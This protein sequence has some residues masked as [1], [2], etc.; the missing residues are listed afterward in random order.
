MKITPDSL[1][2]AAREINKIADE[3]QDSTKFPPLRTEELQNA[4]RFSPL[5]DAVNGADAGS[6]T[7]Q[8]TL[9]K[10]YVWMSHLLFTTAR[11]FNDVDTDLAN[12]LNNMG[13]INVF[14]PMDGQ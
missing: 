11:T 4:M 5:V 2:D 13:S 9:R 1:K 6:N 3:F 7:A 12:S 8:T 14:G 10:R